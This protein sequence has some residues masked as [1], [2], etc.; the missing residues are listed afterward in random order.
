MKK[1]LILIDIQNDYFMGGNMELI[2]MEQA[3]H[4]AEL[5]LRAFRRGQLPVFHIKHISERPGATFFLPD[6]KGVEIHKSVAPQSGENVIEKHFPNSFRDT[7]L[8]SILKISEVEEVV[9][10][11][12]M[13]QM[14][15]DATTRAAF[16]FGFRCTVI[17][18]ACATRNLEHK[19]VLV[20]A[21]IVHAAFMAALA[22]PYA[23]VISA[24][25][26]I[27]KV[28]AGGK[29]I[30]ASLAE[31]LVSHLDAFDKPPHENLS[32][33]EFQILCMV[34]EG[35]T[36]KGIANKLCIS[37][38]TVSTYRSRILEKMKMSTNE[39]LTRY[40]LEHHLV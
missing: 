31:K 27:R 3:A 4:N 38:K 33:R 18:D 37:E 10:C 28:N 2:A 14:C 32:D 26:Y 21:R 22:V 9:I 6:T 12:A 24:H 34:A 5:L 35:K 39:D 20:E 23:K 36:L 30:S 25:E 40:A 29:Y 8:L 19:G 17:E 7:D 11:G 13:S 16:D 15:V 1:G